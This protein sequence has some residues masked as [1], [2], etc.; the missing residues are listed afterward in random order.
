MRK[1]QELI[2][3][4]I[5][6]KILIGPDHFVLGDGFGNPGM[7]TS[8][9]VEPDRFYEATDLHEECIRRIAEKL[10]GQSFDL[11][12]VP[13]DQSLFSA[14]FLARV[15]GGVNKVPVVPVHSKGWGDPPSQAGRILIHD[16]VVNRGRQA[17]EILDR[18]TG[19]SPKPIAI[20][21]LFTRISEAE[22]F[23]LPVFSAVDRVLAATPAE[24]CPLCREDV[25]VN[26]LYGKGALF[27]AL[28]GESP[29]PYIV[30]S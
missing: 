4:F 19:E 13:D 23:G 28:R 16:D 10:A 18:L 17:R 8:L 30:R 15:L 7:H 14:K 11:V 1:V 3:D 12:I 24:D 5:R 27:L 21:S 26:P 9:F 6:R 22:L 2:D 20:S 29:L 25:P